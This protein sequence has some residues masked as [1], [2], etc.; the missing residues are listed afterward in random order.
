[1]E[2]GVLT[3]SSI[4]LLVGPKLRMKKKRRQTATMPWRPLFLPRAARRKLPYTPVMT[5]HSHRVRL[6][7]NTTGS[8]DRTASTLMKVRF[9]KVRMRP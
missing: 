3:R 7:E 4:R 6:R 1:L 2:C 9:Q 5:R 8:S